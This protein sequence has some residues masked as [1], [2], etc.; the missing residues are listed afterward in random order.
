M[1]IFWSRTSPARS[2]RELAYRSEDGVGVTRL[3]LPATDEVLVCVCDHGRGAYFEIRPVN[4]LALDVY[5]HP[6]AYAD[7]SDVRYQDDRL[8]ASASRPVS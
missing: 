2:A 7:F 3:W 4:Y 8:A 6:Y 1:K 5:R